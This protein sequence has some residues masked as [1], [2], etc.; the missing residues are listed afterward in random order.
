MKI[1]IEEPKEGEDEQIVIRCRAMTPELL[2]IVAQLK[3][4]EALMAYQ[5]S[6]IH[7]LKPS[8]V[9]YIESVD[10]K[11]FLYLKD[12][13]LESRQKLYE[14]EE[15]LA[16]GDFLRVSKSAIVNLAKIRSVSPALSGR[17]EA[18]LENGEKVIISRQYT[19]DLK[20]RLGI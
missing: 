9:Y 2:R 20:K 12:K 4:Q 5:G 18:M 8:A 11:T 19:G 6:E 14:L 3:A 17:F 15:A 10:N 7:R 1:V 16:V 13:V